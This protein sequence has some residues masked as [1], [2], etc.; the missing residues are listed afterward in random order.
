LFED[1]HIECATIWRQTEERKIDITCRPQ[2][3]RAIRP[4]PP[5]P[6]AATNIV[7]A[8][9][10]PAFRQAEEQFPLLHQCPLVDAPNTPEQSASAL[11]GLPSSVATISAS[12]NTLVLPHP[13]RLYRHSVSTAQLEPAAPL[14]AKL[15]FVG[16]H[17]S[18]SH[19]QRET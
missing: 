10:S 11:A 17:Y 6:P 12:A 19:H 18:S 3:R 13:R 4:L 7:S 1:I 14:G 9:L 16:Y 2:E 5:S 15:F 8:R